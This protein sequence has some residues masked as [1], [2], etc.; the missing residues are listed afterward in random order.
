MSKNMLYLAAFSN[1]EIIS[2]EG[3]NVQFISSSGNYNICGN[4]SHSLNVIDILINLAGF[5]G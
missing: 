5:M 3:E 2:S 1:V 4:Y